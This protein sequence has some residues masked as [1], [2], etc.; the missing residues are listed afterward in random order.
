MTD[1][2]LIFSK[3]MGNDLSTPVP[4]YNFPGLKEG[5]YWCL[6]A[7]RW[8]EAFEAG[9]A[10]RVKLEACEQSALEVIKLTDLETHAIKD[11]T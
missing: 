5:D 9:M 4:E 10:P 6:C 7:E 11:S 3:Q 1:E 8:Q 2:F